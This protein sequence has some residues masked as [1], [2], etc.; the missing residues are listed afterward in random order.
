M[1]YRERMAGALVLMLLAGAVSTLAAD[2]PPLRLASDIWPPFTNSSG[3]SRVAVDLVHE[4]LE[5]AGVASTTSIV[6]WRAV[7]S[8]IRDN[9]FDGS[10]AVWHT[11]EREQLL[12]Y[13]RPYLENRL[14]LVGRK[15]SDVSA[16][17]LSELAGKRIAIVE[18][19]AY[20]DAVDDAAGP[21]FVEGA[22]DQESLQKLLA[23]EADYMLADELLVRYLMEHQQEETGEFLEIGTRAL[24]RRPLHFALRRDVPGAESI[25]QRFDAAI[26]RMLADGTYN[27]ILQLSWIY[28]DVDG[29][30]RLELVPRNLEAGV[31]AP[32]SGYSIVVPERDRNSV[33]ISERFWIGG[34][35]YESWEQVPPEF[36]VPAG[37]AA[38][39]GPPSNPV[40]S[41]SFRN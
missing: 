6:G 36:K 14:V 40:I 28:A 12:V 31:V 15:G 30:G 33:R 39:V 3:E 4:A 17:S 26:Q 19:Y 13:S 9:L 2:P 23:G 16:L 32:R 35:V 25:I 38:D 8:G 18:R 5:R 10:A 11:P 41:L 1:R 34:Q 24:I 27:E 7:T 20:G 37:S 29:D 21:R 22:N